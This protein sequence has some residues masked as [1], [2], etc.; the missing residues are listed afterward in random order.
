M[1]IKHHR[2]VAWN[3]YMDYFFHLLGFLSSQLTKSYFCRY[4]TNQQVPYF[5]TPLEWWGTILYYTRKMWNWGSSNYSTSNTHMIENFYT[6]HMCVCI[7][8]YKTWNY[9][10]IYIWIYIYM[11]I[12]IWICIYIYIWIYIWICIYIICVYI[13]MN[14]YI[15]ILYIYHTSRHL[16]YTSYISLFLRSYPVRIPRPWSWCPGP[17]WHFARRCPTPMAAGPL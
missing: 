16:D 10:Y 7:Y 15:Y 9:I 3:I 2:L 1:V 8:I 4:T 12:Y 17:T 14:M 13:Y 5:Q 6:S 11:N